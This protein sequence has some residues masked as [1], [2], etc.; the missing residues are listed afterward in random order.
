MSSSHAQHSSWSS[1]ISTSRELHLTPTFTLMAFVSMSL[2]AQDSA[3]SAG[4]FGTF[5]N[6]IASETRHKTLE[7]IAA[8]FG[9]KV[10]EVGEREVEAEGNVL[11][12]K[13]GAR[14]IEKMEK[15]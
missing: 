6:R 9:D 3:A 7:E 5:A 8:A 2:D 4:K 10:V 12:E 1:R 11:D 13:A 14:H 15:V